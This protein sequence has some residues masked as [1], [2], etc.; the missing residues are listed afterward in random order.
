MSSP[1]KGDS[2]NVTLSHQQAAMLILLLQ[3]ITNDPWPVTS[4]L[5]S[6]GSPHGGCLAIDTSPSCSSSTGPRSSGSSSVFSPGAVQRLP[7]H[8]TMEFSWYAT[9]ASE[10][11]CRYSSDD[12]FQVKPR[13]R[14]AS[15]AHSFCHV[16]IPPKGEP[17]FIHRRGV[18]W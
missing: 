18:I 16:G 1:P 2:V 13:N 4:G 12:L 5:M 11:S 8:S 15:S 9:D 14:K 7:G 3:H 10:S 17:T 6:V